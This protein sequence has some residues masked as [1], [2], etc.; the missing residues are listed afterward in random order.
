MKQG[1]VI[2][3]PTYYLLCMIIMSIMTV[4]STL[5]N[6]Q[7]CMLRAQKCKKLPPLYSS[8]QTTIVSPPKYVATRSQGAGVLFKVCSYL[9]SKCWCIVQIHSCWLRSDT[10]F[11]W[12]FIAPAVLIIL[13]SHT[14]LRVSSCTCSVERHRLKY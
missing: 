6:K 2:M 5:Y 11:V 7:L 4:R 13:V 10:H 3:L 1:T 8:L 14:V 12:A 9:I